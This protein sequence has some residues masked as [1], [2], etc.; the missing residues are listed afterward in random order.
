MLRRAKFPAI[1]AV[2]LAG[3]LSAACGDAAVAKDAEQEVV[4]F[5][6]TVVHRDLSAA[7]G[8]L[9]DTYKETIRF[10]AFEKRANLFLSSDF[11]PIQRIYVQDSRPWGEESGD[12]RWVYVIV[13]GRDFADA[14]RGIV[15]KENGQLRIRN[16]AWS[17]P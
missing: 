15:K 6:A 1:A 8:R 12:V 5:A 10:D 9:A 14:I 16:V 2:L 3:A 4:A 13:E 11:G 7:Y 17:K